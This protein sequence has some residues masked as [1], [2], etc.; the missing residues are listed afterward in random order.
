M[1]KMKLKNNN[2]K[3][4]KIIK[5]KYLLYIIIIYLSLTTSYYLNMKYNKIITNRDIIETLLNDGSLS[6]LNNIKT[7]KVVGKTMNL[8]FNIDIK[9]PHTILNNTIINNNKTI[10]KI[11]KED[12]AITL[13]EVE[14]TSNYIEDPNPNTNNNPIVYLYNTHQLENYNNDYL[15]IYGITP[16]V[17]MAS[18]MLKE[19]LNN[20]GI[21]TI[22]E[23]TDITDTLKLKNWPYYKSYDITRDLINNNKQKYQTLKYF[24]DIHRD[25]ISK[26]YT[27]INIDNKYYA[28]VL[29]VLGLENKKYNNN[30][31]LMENINHLIEESYPGLSRGILKKEGPNVNGIY[32]QDIDSNVIL[33]E[34]GSSDNTIEEVYNT[35]NALSIILTKYIGD[36]KN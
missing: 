10:S 24:I 29:F 9:N 20:N 17:Q 13:E 14:K 28:R 26:E 2:K 8:I 1:A 18:Y 16:N 27:T 5:Y 11:A 7:T 15:K 34:V 12:E 21:N 31:K 25:S 4:K 33:I 3:K 32:N 19:K 30:L 35:I 22:V 23:E 36:D 6:T